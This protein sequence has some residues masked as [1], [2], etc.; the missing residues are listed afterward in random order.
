MFFDDKMH[1]KGTLTYGNGYAKYEGSFRRGKFHGQGT[2]LH[3][4]GLYVGNFDQGFYS[5]INITSCSFN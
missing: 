4:D 2:Y 3:D 1:G 5:G